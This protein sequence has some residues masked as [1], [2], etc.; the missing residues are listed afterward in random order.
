MH[1]VRV[2]HNELANSK[3]KTLK[4]IKKYIEDYEAD[5]KD[6]EMKRKAVNAKKTAQKKREKKQSK[7]SHQ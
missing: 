1:R 3:D 5:N 7:D 4:K 6:V 2:K